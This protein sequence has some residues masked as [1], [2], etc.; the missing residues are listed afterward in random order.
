MAL[1]LV[2]ALG[3][4]PGYPRCHLTALQR[5]LYTLHPCE[6]LGGGREGGLGGLD[7]CIVLVF[8]TTYLTYLLYLGSIGQ[9]SA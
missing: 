5:S 3:S 8:K 6:L 9:M 7:A 4:G 2:L 1:E